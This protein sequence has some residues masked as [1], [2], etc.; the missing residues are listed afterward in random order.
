MLFPIQSINAQCPSTGC[1]TT[2][3][4]VNTTNYTVNV[5]QKLC[6]ASGAIY[7]GTVTMNGGTLENCATAPQS[8]GLLY[9]GATSSIVNNYGTVSFASVNIDQGIF[10]NYG[11]YLE[12][13]NIDIQNT[14]IF[15]NYDSV[16]SGANLVV[17]NSAQFINWGSLDVINNFDVIN[18]GYMENHGYIHGHDRFKIGSEFYNTGVILIDGLWD[19]VA[20]GGT[21]TNDGGCVTM[22]RLKNE[23]GIFGLN[24][25][26]ITI[27]NS[28][29]NFPTGTIDGNIA[30]VDNATYPFVDVN[31]G[32][33]GASVIGTSCGC[34]GP[35]DNC[36]DT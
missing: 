22:D 31:S 18:D 9:S 36:H 14:A 12:S 27:A 15:N 2:I 26:T 30:I 5:G 29:E 21:F 32:F 28:S 3:S 4:G 17:T 34:P 8:F 23:V 10:N 7:S 33:V 1:T 19:N 13:N 6:L 25:G 20:P 35:G 24:C 11:I 16:Y